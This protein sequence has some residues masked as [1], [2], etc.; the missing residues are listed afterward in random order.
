MLTGFKPLVDSRKEKLAN[1]I[2]RV[3]ANPTNPV[4]NLLQKD[5]HY[6]ESTQEG[7]MKFQQLSIFN[8][9]KEIIKKHA[10]LPY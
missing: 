2:V 7:M 5:D 6:E 1:Y 4:N 3:I 9:T 10:I 8:R